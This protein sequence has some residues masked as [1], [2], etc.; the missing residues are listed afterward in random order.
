MVSEAFEP[1]PPE[2]RWRLY[3]RIA[4]VFEEAGEEEASKRIRAIAHEA[5]RESPLLQQEIKKFLDE[6]R[7]VVDAD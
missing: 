1:L 7:R 5:V 4:D 6:V 2:R 3:N